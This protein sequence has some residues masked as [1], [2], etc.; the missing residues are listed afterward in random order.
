MKRLVLAALAV[1]LMAASPL[2]TRLMAQPADSLAATGA[3]PLVVVSFS[4]YAELQKDANYIGQLVEQ[5]QLAQ[6]LDGAIMMGTG[7][8]GLAGV[9]PN[10][11]WGVVMQADGQAFPTVGF[12]PVNNI[13]ELV[14]LLESLDLKVTDKGDGRYEVVT[15]AQ[16]LAMR[17][18]D[19]W[20]YVADSADRLEQLPNNPLQRLGS[21]P[22]KYD[23]A[24]LVHVVN[25]PEQIRGQA[26]GALTMGAA[27]AAQRQPG[28]SDEEYAMRKMATENA[29]KQFGKM[30]D[31]LDKI[32]IG[33]NIDQQQQA[34]LVDVAVSAQPNT[35]LAQQ[36]AGM[37]DVK[38]D[39]H[40]FADNEA[41]VWANWAGTM[42]DDDAAQAKAYLTQFQ[43][44]AEET[45]AKQDLSEEDLAK[46]KE[47]LGKLFDV[48]N[49]NVDAKHSD[50]G[51]AVYAGEDRLTLTAGGYLVDG[52]KLENLVKEFVEQLAT[53]KPEIR[54]LVK[55]DTDKHAGVNFHALSVPAEAFDDA[56]EQIKQLMGSPVEAI[57]GI[58]PNS[59]YL[60]VGKDARSTLRKVIDAS[61][62]AK[63]TSIS[64][65]K[66]VVKLTPILKAVAGAAQQA[67]VSQATDMVLAA[68][69]K[70]PGRDKLL[71]ESRP[72]PNGSMTRITIEEG[73]LRA[74][75]AGVK[76][77]M[78]NSAAGPG[79][80]PGVVPPQGEHGGFDGGGF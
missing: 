47:M 38:T 75:G 13:D 27:G 50:G 25:L 17:F 7:G 74:I 55:L 49:E 4:G 30:L 19:G 67:E 34:A 73:I 72:I 14:G 2:T 37:K 5:P 41:A 63:G 52:P 21:L 79:M 48:I 18:Q 11:P 60:S 16:P 68:V 20:A 43:T 71:V 31:E 66:V 32:L 29:I 9:D 61:Q 36:F 42:S 24:V 54:T 39:F 76:Q 70:A 40:G 64:P 69:N 45:L 26:M 65:A 3:K 1:A 8:R 23:I 62:A 57:V 10:R 22:K 78:Q 46:A 12:L 59:I 56:S 33:I 15:P 51:M 35:S 44:S 28:E 6:M 77:A 80:R 58:G 53:E